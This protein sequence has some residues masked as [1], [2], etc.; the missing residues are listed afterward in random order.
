M[1]IEFTNRGVNEYEDFE[2]DFI[3]SG[4]EVSGSIIVENDANAEGRYRLGIKLDTPLPGEVGILS[5]SKERHYLGLAD[6]QQL[7]AWINLA[8]GQ[9]RS[10]Y[11]HNPPRRIE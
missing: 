7:A 4:T 11:D 5:E 2:A 6:E 1:N 3:Q 8:V 9:V 10:R